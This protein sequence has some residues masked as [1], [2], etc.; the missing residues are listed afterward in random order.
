MPGCDRLEPSAGPNSYNLTLT[1]GIGPVKGTYGGKV[2]LE[3]IRPIY[4]YRMKVEGKGGPGFIKGEGEIDL[5]EADGATT[6]SYRGDIQIGGTLASVGGRMIQGSSKMMIDQFFTAI[7]AEAASSPGSPPPK[8]G[9][10]RN[11][12]RALLKRFGR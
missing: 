10:F 3:D 1:V 9:F 5:A 8:H 12:L 2:Q 7:E 4:H 11:L 6:I